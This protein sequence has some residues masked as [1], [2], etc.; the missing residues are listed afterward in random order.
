MSLRHERSNSAPAPPPLGSS[1]SVP[2]RT[3]YWLPRTIRPTREGWWFIGA[4]FTVGLA[5]TNTGNNLLYLILAMM[6]SFM[7]VSGML[8]EQALRRLRL[9]REMPRRIF[10]GMPALFGVRLQNRK[11]HLPSYALHLAE[12]NPAGGPDALGFF[13]KVAPQKR[14]SWLYPLTFPRRGRHYLPGLRLFTLFPFG[15]FTKS[16]RPVLADPVLVYP[17]VRP[18]APDEIPTALQAGWRE[19]YRRGQGA[20]L[21]NLRPYRAGDD[22]RLVHWRTS[23][24]TGELILKELEEEDRPQIRLIVEDPFPGTPAEA[25]EADLSSVA[26]LAAH[27]IRQ[28]ASLELLTAEG[29][30]GPGAGESH[31]DRILERLALYLVPDAPRPLRAAGETGRE[32][33]FR[34]GARGAG[35]GSEGEE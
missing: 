24:R 10:A 3:R 4:T 32:V 27:A 34:L 2:P 25:V 22:P 17:A 21:Y 20:G 12:T 7:V 35:R 30:S 11:R 19:R 6:L 29:S 5:A 33:R 1:A 9:Q 13:L 8:S 16:G 15:L 18:L 28:G 31:L 14:E 23:A 26:S